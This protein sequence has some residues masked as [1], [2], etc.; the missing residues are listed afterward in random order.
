VPDPEEPSGKS[1]LTTTIELLISNNF[2]NG[3]AA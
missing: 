3:T 1:T 2:S